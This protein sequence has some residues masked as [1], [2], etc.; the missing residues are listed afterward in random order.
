[1]TMPPIG[2]AGFPHP[3]TPEVVDRRVRSAGGVDLSRGI[4]LSV[5]RDKRLHQHRWILVGNYIVDEKGMAVLA[6]TVLAAEAR[7]AADPDAPIEQMQIPYGPDTMVGME[8]PG[9]A[10]CGIVWHD[11]VKGYGKLCDVS[12]KDYDPTGVVTPPPGALK[13]PPNFTWEMTANLMQQGLASMSNWALADEE[14]RQFM[15]QL[16]TALGEVLKGYKEIHETIRN[17]GSDPGV[18][19]PLEK[20]LDEDPSD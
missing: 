15:T 7:R 8:G 19:D 4:D 6:E 2:G 10:K 9:C 11:K 20:L 3:E 17:M 16:Y 14:P 13:I 12:D 18:G 1:M 5:V